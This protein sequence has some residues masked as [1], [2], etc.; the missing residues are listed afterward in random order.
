MFK[1]LGLFIKN[2]LAL[3]RPQVRITVP[4][5]RAKKI[6]V[7]ADH[8]D[9]NKKAIDQF[10]QSLEK[11]G[12]KVEVIGFSPKKNKPALRVKYKAFSK[13]DLSWTGE[14]K[15][16][17]LKKFIKTDFDY[18]FSLNTSPFLPFENILAQSKAKCR[19]GVYQE[20]KE[21]YFELMVEP[22]KKNDMIAVTEQMIRYTKLL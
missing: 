7:L 11:E 12:K 6:G 19:I 15:Q 1:S 22:K 3:K 4:F 5:I 14:I 21:G 17:E 9:E 18:L 10:V 13:K 2:K 16:E 20:K 8:L